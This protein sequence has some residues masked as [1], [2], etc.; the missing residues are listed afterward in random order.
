MRRR[1]LEGVL[2]SRLPLLLLPKTAVVSGRRG[3][4]PGQRLSGMG[5]G[6]GGPLP[7]LRWRLAG[8]ISRP[9]SGLSTPLASHITP[10]LKVL[11]PLSFKGRGA[12][13]VKARRNGRGPWPGAA[14]AEAPRGILAQIRVRSWV[15]VVR[16]TLR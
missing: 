14:E 16:R 9:T 11:K 1:A 15:R 12:A 6:R 5:V 2:H 10:V 4:H 3:V 8:P 7:E 13:A